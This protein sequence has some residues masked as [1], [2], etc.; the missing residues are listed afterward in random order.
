NNALCFPYIFRG[1][2]D[3]GATVVNEAM[4]VACV[5]AIA[6]MAHVESS[7]SAAYGNDASSFGREYLIPGPLDPRLIMAIA[8]AVA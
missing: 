7:E 4:K 3:S 5:H 2:L 1:A 6:K 8:P